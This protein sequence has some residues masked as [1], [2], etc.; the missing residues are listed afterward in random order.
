MALDQLYYTAARSGLHGY[1]GFQIVAAS[2]QLAS[3]HAAKTKEALRLCTYELPRGAAAADPPISFGWWDRSGQRYAFQRVYLGDD[4]WGRPGNFA[5]HILAG[6]PRTLP[7][8]ALARS[9][10][11]PFWWQG[12][13]ERLGPELERGRLPEVQLAEI[14]PGPITEP[15][16]ELFAH[17][18]AAL[19]GAP[20]SFVILRLD[21]DAVAAVI[22][23]V[24]NLL[25]ELLDGQSVSTYEGPAT[26]MRFRL[27][28]SSDEATL[29]RSGALLVEPGRAPQ[30]DPAIVKLALA[31]TDVEPRAREIAA[32]ALSAARMRTGKASLSSLQQ[33]IGALSRIGEGTREGDVREMLAVPEVRTYLGER[34]EGRSLVIESALGGQQTAWSSIVAAIQ[35][36]ERGEDWMRTLARLL[37]ERLA[38]RRGT[39]IL[40]RELAGLTLETD[41]EKAAPI[42]VLA[43]AILDD[44]GVG[45]SEEAK[46]DVLARIAA[47]REPDYRLRFLAALADDRSLRENP[48]LEQEVVETIG[49]FALGRL[50]E[51]AGVSL[52]VAEERLL[53]H[54]TGPGVEAWL[55]LS[56]LRRLS[57]G[58]LV[59]ETRR[60]L[61]LIVP[62]RKD[63]PL[64]GKAWLMMLAAEIMRSYDIFDQ[65]SL[66][67]VVEALELCAQETGTS[68][69][70][71]EMVMQLA[72]HGGSG[73]TSMLKLA[74]VA[75]V[76]RCVEV[77]TLALKR[78]KLDDT[79]RR[80]KLD[81][82]SLQAQAEILVSQLGPLEHDALR[83]WASFNPRHGKRWE[84]GLH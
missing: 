78:T 63:Y 20:R 74:A 8:P 53:D 30:V 45:L 66:V 21:S 32:A 27:V 75:Y 73:R 58:R 31:L 80:A 7:L 71:A 41:P 22:A 48:E 60:L 59:E 46:I 67:R 16:Q 13:E 76:L 56:R 72:S 50:D 68:R 42:L 15:P 2:P 10:R 29:P 47:G 24:A 14:A 4:P 11:S 12:E 65:A 37:R 18:L 77:E 33:A 6:T 39:E 43:M 49:R 28:G 17:A 81:D 23:A 5:A 57:R 3:R 40:A 36:G 79:L 55:R 52:D 51:G 26:A 34:E 84:K 19:L 83:D 9:Y 64:S 44:E 69:A 54:Y 70:F 25:P 35:R 38:S 62:L 1:G 82:G 61:Q